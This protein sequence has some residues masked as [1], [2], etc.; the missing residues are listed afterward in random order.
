MLNK[1]DKVY[2]RG[3]KIYGEY[4]VTKKAVAILVSNAL[5]CESY[6]KMSD[7]EED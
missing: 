4:I 1:S 2:I 6:K 3:C 7:Y 5:Y